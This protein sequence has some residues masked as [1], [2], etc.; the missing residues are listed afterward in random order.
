MGMKLLQN[1]DTFEVMEWAYLR[2]DRGKFIPGLRGFYKQR[3]TP[4]I[5]R[6]RRQ[7]RHLRFLLDEKAK[8]SCDLCPFPQPEDRLISPPLCRASQRDAAGIGGDGS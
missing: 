3:K 2:D 6:S 1:S 5:P 4:I 8:L 7:C